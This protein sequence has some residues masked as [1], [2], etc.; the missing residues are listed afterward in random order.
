M[1]ADSEVQAASGWLAGDSNNLS[2]LIG[3]STTPLA[4]SIAAVL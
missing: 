4:E 1:L 3:R 2:Q